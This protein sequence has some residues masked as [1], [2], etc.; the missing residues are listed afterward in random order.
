MRL[1]K[2]FSSRSIAGFALV[3]MLCLSSQILNAAT[4]AVTTTNDE[5][6][7][8]GNCSL[9]EAISEINAAGGAATDC[10]SSGAFGT[11][12]TINVPTG[13]YSITIPGACEQ[14]NATGD[15]DLVSNGKNL[16]NLKIVGAGAGLTII[17]GNNL[18][19]VFDINP[20]GPT[21]ADVK[22][23]HLTI[24]GGNAN[25][26][27]G[28]EP[29]GG[30][31]NMGFQAATL[32]LSDV[33]VTDNEAS[34]GGGIINGQTLIVEQS[35]ING[36]H[37][38]A[39]AGNGGGISNAVATFSMNCTIINST[40]SENIAEGA[41]GCGG[42]IGFYTPMS[43]VIIRTN[44]RN[45]TMTANT[46]A[47]GGGFAVCATPV[48]VMS[49]MPLFIRNTIIAANVDSDPTTA[50]PDCFDGQGKLN[51]TSE[52]YNLLGDN[53]GCST[54][55]WAATDQVGDVAGGGA[56]IDPLLNALADNG[57]ETPTNA[58]KPT[59]T[60]LDGANPVGC[61]SDDAAT[62]LLTID[63]R[64]E[65]RPVD[66]KGTGTAICDIGAYEYQPVCG[67][68]IVQPPE[69]CD[70]GQSNSDTVADACRTTCKLAFC[71]DNVVDTGEECDEGA[72]NG[73]VGGTCSANCE[74][75]A[76]APAP[77]PTDIQLSGDAFTRCT[78]NPSATGSAASI[79][80]LMIA[81]AGMY[82]TRSRRK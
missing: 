57:G 49:G 18:D 30:I 68:N 11:D 31:R 17:D 81:L 72:N 58:L 67:D 64:A 21:T 14:V 6:N 15:F 43:A 38:T 40:I 44:L 82:I 34:S 36:N 47:N 5:L 76:P 27:Q 54:E 24:R 65:P 48:P 3:A 63:Q 4:I 45:V 41:Q 33:M 78:L 26:C 9:R 42:G 19:R 7:N 2:I 39:I 62:V 29:G 56:A 55:P 37:A 20:S 16:L 13:T 69:E 22:I 77:A 59:S 71:G 50:N 46:A 73:A 1:S 25:M 79:A 8:D 75:V 28:S 12:D 74:S 32:T 66:G 80:Y 52:G 23:S 35:S 10:A 51:L 53:R 60:A 70:N 61:F